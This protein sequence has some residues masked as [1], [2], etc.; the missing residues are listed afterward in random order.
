MYL[1]KRCYLWW[2]YSEPLKYTTGAW[3]S[4]AVSS[5]PAARLWRYGMELTVWNF[6]NASLR[7][8][9][10]VGADLY[11]L[12]RWFEDIGASWTF[13][14]FPLFFLP[15]GCSFLRTLKEDLAKVCEEEELRVRKEEAERLSKLRATITSETEAEKEKIRWEVLPQQAGSCHPYGHKLWVWEGSILHAIS[16]HSGDVVA[17]LSFP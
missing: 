7:H 14:F 17:S 10:W 6:G 8:V 5:V 11:A 9:Q 4:G 2:Q 16:I 12:G 3:C 15:P 13:Y 1:G